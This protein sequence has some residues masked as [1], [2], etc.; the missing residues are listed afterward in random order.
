M[1]SRGHL[2]DPT[3][4]PETGER[5]ETLASVRGVVVEH[6]LSSA[7]DVAVRYVQDQDEWVVVLAGSA[8]VDVDGERH[9]L[10]AGDWVL[11]P[12]RVP[13]TVVRTAAATAWLAVHIPPPP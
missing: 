11:L 3:E 2:D 6:I 5:F 12:A 7:S 8:V 9:D 1:L 13:H 10:G 4:A